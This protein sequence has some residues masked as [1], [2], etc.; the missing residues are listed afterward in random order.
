ME[1]KLKQGGD[2]VLC[3]WTGKNEQFRQYHV[4]RAK[5]Y[6]W[7]YTLVL[8]GEKL[9]LSKKAKDEQYHSGPEIPLCSR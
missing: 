1:C 5:Y 7:E 4:Y 2:I 6:W 3:H 9:A 8:W